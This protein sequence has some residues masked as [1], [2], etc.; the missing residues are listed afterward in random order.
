MLLM[1]LL[2]LMTRASFTT[3]IAMEDDD[4]DDNKNGNNDSDSSKHDNDDKNNKQTLISN[5][6]AQ[7]KIP[8]TAHTT[9]DILPPRFSLP[10]PVPNP[11][12]IPLVV[13]WVELTP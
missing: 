2:L 4:S 10:P 6:V 8:L 13:K 9:Q 3:V 5:P 7:P 12:K 11:V 1:L